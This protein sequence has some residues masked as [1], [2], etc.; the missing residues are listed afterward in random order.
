MKIRP[1]GAA[2]LHADRRTD[3]TKLTDDFLAL[4]ERVFKAEDN[5]VLDKRF[6]RR[7][8]NRLATAYEREATLRC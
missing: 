3:M 6:F 5:P 4:C 8:S 2:L 1:V 7:D